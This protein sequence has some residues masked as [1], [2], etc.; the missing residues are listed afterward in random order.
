MTK[1]L[2]HTVFEKKSIEIPDRIAVSHGDK[3]SSY[4]NLNE[5]GNQLAHLLN[6]MVEKPGEVVGMMLPPGRES[7]IALISIFKSGNVY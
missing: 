7:I 6:K 3:K 4:K 2:I 1:Q 5:S